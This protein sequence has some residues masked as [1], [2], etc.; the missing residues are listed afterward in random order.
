[1]KKIL[2]VSIVFISFHSMAQKSFFGVDAGV[3][4]AN[5]RQHVDFGSNSY[6]ETTTNFFKNL[7]A[8]TFGAFYQNQFN[9]KIGLRIGAQFLGLGSKMPMKYFYI[10][11][12]P[13]DQVNIYYFTIPLTFHYSVTEHLSFYAGPYLS[14]TYGG[15]KINGEP[16]TKIFHK[17]DH[18]FSFGAEH[19]VYKN[20]AIGVMYIFGLKNIWLN[21]TIDNGFGVKENKYTNRAL[22]LTLIYKFKKTP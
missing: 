17:N 2:A 8:P 22:Q 11:G 10:N 19:D 9:D 15:T 21:D 18:G 20:F 5:Q 12:A 13:V 14:F 1:M 4:I 7:V 16:I 3:N 6:P